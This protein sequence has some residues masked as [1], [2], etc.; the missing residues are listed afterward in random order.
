MDILLIG[1]LWLDGTAWHAVTPALRELGHQPRPLTLP[2]TVSTTLDEQLAAVL[3]AVD[4]ASGPVMVVA[5]SANCNLGWLA[6][7][8]RPERIASLVM[9]GGFPQADGQ[10]YADLFEIRD[11]VMPFPGWAPFEGPDAADIDE[12]LRQQIAANAI[13]VPEGVARALVHLTDPRRY[14]VPITMVSPEYTPDQVRAWIAAGQAPELAA[15]KHVEILDFDS[16]HWPMFTKPT[17][18][19]HL[20]ADL[21]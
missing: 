3:A 10:L 6:A 8:A 4:A 11:G 16:G 20:L 2:A 1:G 13:P 19:A 21:T 17:E 12:S 9:V 7:D 15:A 5:H 18:L 14:D